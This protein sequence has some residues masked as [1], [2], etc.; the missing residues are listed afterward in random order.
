[1]PQRVALDPHEARPLTSREISKI[2]GAMLS[3]VLTQEP[4]AAKSMPQAFEHIKWLRERIGTEPSSEA[5]VR[6]LQGLS[7]D[8]V[9]QQATLLTSAG[10]HSSG[11]ST[12]FTALTATVSGFHGWCSS[13]AVDDA[14]AWWS[15]NWR[16]LVPH[17]Q[18]QQFP[19]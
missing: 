18:R 12:W 1:M 19:D 10:L 2:L 14:V 9:T 3:G 7:M 6:R 16:E 8:E 13:K 17:G 4:A 15:E 11:R 5:I